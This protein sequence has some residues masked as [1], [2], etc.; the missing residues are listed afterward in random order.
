MRRVSALEFSPDGTYL[1]AGLNG[2]GFYV[3]NTTSLLAS[4]QPWSASFIAPPPTPCLPACRCDATSYTCIG[5]N[6]SAF[7][8]DMFRGW[9]ALETINLSGNN[10]SSLPDGLFAGL[11]ALTALDI[12]GNPL[13]SLPGGWLAGARALVTLLLS[14]LPLNTTFD[15][16]RVLG[17][18]LPALTTLVLDSPTLLGG[19]GACP[20]LS[21]LAVLAPRLATLYAR[22]GLT[23]IPARSFAG[24]NLSTLELSY[25]SLPALT[26][27]S[28]DGLQVGE[29]KLEWSGIAA[30]EARA[31]AGLT[32]GNVDL[33]FNQIS[34]ARLPAGGLDLPGV[35]AL[36][37][38]GNPFDAR[39]FAAPLFASTPRLVSLDMMGGMGLGP[40]L[41]TIP[42][43]AFAGAPGLTTLQL[44][45]SGITGLAPGAFEGL[46]RLLNLNI[47][48]TNSGNSGF[49][50]VPAGLLDPLPTLQT[51]V[52]NNAALSGAD[53]LR[54]D[55]FAHNPALASLDLS[56][57]SPGLTSLPAGLLAGCDRLATIDLS[58][59]AG[60]QLTL[61]RGTFVGINAS[62]T[63]AAP[64]S[65]TLVHNQ[66]TGYAGI[67]SE[68]E[69]VAAICAE[70]RATP[71]NCTVAWSPQ[72]DGAAS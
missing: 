39:I 63:L 45:N 36:C 55:A 65:I 66:M 51:L 70:A 20:D 59:A 60:A 33:Y 21:S 26:N 42:P 14:G 69:I 44:F 15:V 71:A 34:S 68:P 41:G 30:I 40:W 12:S 72:T 61:A 29:V 52:I 13:R 6:L 24:L 58:Y 18:T 43:R 19:G 1:I 27:D 37:L 11:P 2:G 31:F 53:A 5:R 57:N 64:V 10:A 9:S 17:G 67:T 46:P 38:A 22:H 62:G 32:A 35:A 3:S 4:A 47:G 49:S 16:A 50:A 25:S 23:S 7:P 54:A 28:F 48:G 56:Y 8:A